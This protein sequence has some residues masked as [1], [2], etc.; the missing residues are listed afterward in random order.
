MLMYFF[1]EE[2]K[3]VQCG[4]GGYLVAWVTQYKTVSAVGL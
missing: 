3:G 2:T 4:G 1:Q